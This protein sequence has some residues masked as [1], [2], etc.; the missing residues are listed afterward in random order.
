[1]ET[2]SPQ[3]FSW[4]KYSFQKE[5]KFLGLESFSFVTAIFKLFWGRVKKVCDR[6]LSKDNIPVAF[7][8]GEDYHWCNHQILTI[9]SDKAVWY[10]LKDRINEDLFSWLVWAW[11]A[12]FL[13]AHTFFVQVCF[14]DPV[15]F[16]KTGR[17]WLVQS[18]H[19]V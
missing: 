12:S 17:V 1:M 3:T 11:S 16:Y 4:G 10:V 7:L 6:G 19:L 5:W 14:A 8:K 13:R 18:P 15:A 2:L 9:N